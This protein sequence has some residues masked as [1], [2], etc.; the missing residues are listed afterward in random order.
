LCGP[1]RPECDETWG[2]VVC[3]RQER[4]AVPDFPVEGTH[5]PRLSLPDGLETQ[6]K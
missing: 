3:K 5:K 4:L 6:E 1:V 2:E